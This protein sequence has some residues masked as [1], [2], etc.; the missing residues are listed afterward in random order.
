MG[1]IVIDI[2]EKSNFFGSF[3]PQ[4]GAKNATFVQGGPPPSCRVNPRNNG[5]FPMSVCVSVTKELMNW[6]IHTMFG[7]CRVNGLAAK[8]RAFG[9]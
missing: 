7:K 4:K 2:W 1:G 6:L 5:L 9:H 8:R 3:G